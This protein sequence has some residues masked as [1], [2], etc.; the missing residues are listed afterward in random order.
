MRLFFIGTVFLVGAVTIAACS[1]D[2]A[3]SAGGTG[4]ASAGGSSAGGEA[5]SGA[6]A[7]GGGSQAG[8]GGEAGEGGTAGAAG[9]AAGGMGGGA[10]A[11]GSGGSGGVD[12]TY[13]PVGGA[14]GGAPCAETEVLPKKLPVDIVFAVDTSGSMS[15]EIA[16]VKANINGSFADVLGA[17]ALDYRVAMI[18]AKGTGTFQ[19]CVDPPLGGPNCGDNYPIFKAVPQTV[20]S[21][22]ALSLILSTYDSATLS[23]NWSGFIRQESTKVIIVVTDDNSSLA[24]ASFDTQLLAK[25]PADV[26]GNSM[27]RKYIFYGIIGID[28]LNPAVKCPA[29]VNNGAQYQTLV[30]L[31]GGQ[32][33]SECELDYSPIF[34]SIA[35][36]VVSQLSCEYTLPENDP[37]GQAI[38]PNNVTVKFVDSMMVETIFPQV[39]DAASCA[40]LGWYYEDNANPSQILL[41]PD[42]CTMVQGDG[43]GEVKIVVGCLEG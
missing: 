3:S 1:S 32:M 20:A 24:A 5:G 29:A 12:F 28:P 8:S 42:A 16:Q 15:T 6:V 14:G 27:A 2:E 11:G 36:N 9:A 17:G 19:V 41:C 25:L 38:D 10:G 34:Q 18:A 35:S 13:D 33:F 30:G 7:G 31:T 26:F 37:T 23:L 21:T 22:N 43:G 40:G 39:L 4:G